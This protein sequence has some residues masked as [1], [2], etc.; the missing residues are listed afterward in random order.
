MLHVCYIQYL[1]SPFLFHR[2]YFFRCAQCGIVEVQGPPLSQ[3]VSYLD[4][5]YRSCDLI[6]ASDGGLHVIDRFVIN[7]C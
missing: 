2:S 6:T 4:R 5:W 3:C 1:S 7:D